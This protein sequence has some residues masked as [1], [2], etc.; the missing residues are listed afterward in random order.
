MFLETIKKNSVFKF[1]YKLP[2][3]VSLYHFSL[4]FLGGLLYG[5]PSRK[6]IVIGVTGTKGK[7]T[8]CNLIKQILEGAGRKTGMITTVN[9]SDG[10]KEWI[11]DLKQT[12]PGRFMLQK[13]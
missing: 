9:M 1:F 7:T 3:L 12:M 6:L 11:N 13:L 2:W 8:T 5:F 10:D 4:A